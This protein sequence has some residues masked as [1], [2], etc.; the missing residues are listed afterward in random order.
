MTR[1]VLTIRQPWAWAIAE[2]PWYTGDYGLVLSDPEPLPE[3][4]PWRKGQQQI[5]R[6]PDELVARASRGVL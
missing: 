1:K 4:I 6:M 2:Q 5:W 3:P